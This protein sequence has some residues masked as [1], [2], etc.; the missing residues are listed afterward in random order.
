MVLGVSGSPLRHGKKDMLAEPSCM[1]DCF[2]SIRL[3]C[4]SNGGFGYLG[5]SIM[6]KCT[7]HRARFA[8]GAGNPNVKLG[9]EI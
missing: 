1:T 6:F 9:Y 8:A 2:E 7:I 3:A 4:T 5:L